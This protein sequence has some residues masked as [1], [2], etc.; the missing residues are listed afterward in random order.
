MFRTTLFLLSVLALSGC[1][2]RA[3]EPVASTAA[4]PKEYAL[5]GEVVA[6]SQE[7]GTVIAKHDE[8]PGYMPPMTME[9]SFEPADQAKLVEGKRFR[10]RLVDDGK[11]NLHLLAVEPIDEAK[12]QQVRAAANQLRQDTAM[13]GK[14]AYREVGETVPQF[15]LY[16]QEGNVVSFERFRGRRV[17]L[18]FIY[19]R[20]PG[21]C[22]VQTSRQVALQRRIPQVL[23]RRVRFLSLSL[24]PAQGYRYAF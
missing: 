1:A 22:P 10:A 3:A 8:I 11:G 16:N 17:V 12:E 24:D 6:F 18:N 19:T 5:C 15:S 21:P 13:R 2:K 7:R 23:R 9:F 20:C 4:S 14:G